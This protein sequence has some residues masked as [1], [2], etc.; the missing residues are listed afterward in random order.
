MN[1]KERIIKVVAAALE[2][3]PDVNLHRFPVQIEF[4][5]GVLTLEGEVERIT[6]KKK[7]LEVAAAVSG[8]TGIVDRLRLVP[9]TQMQDDEI[10]DHVCNT[11]LAENSLGSCAVWAI[12]KKKPEVIREADQGVDG[13]IDVEVNDGVVILNGTVTS[14][15]AKRLAGVLAWWVPG[16]R[17]VVNGIEVAPPEEDDD[18]EVVD[19]VRLVL[20]KDPFVNAAQIRVTCRNYAVTLEGIVKNET[21]RQIAEADCWYVFRVDR[22]MNLLQVEE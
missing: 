20:E 3:E 19:A 6:A 13:S 15:S 18:D 2:R 16:S 1:D 4:D 12:V 17:D 7:A 11:L 22:I 8:V 14:L 21:Q 10:R 5:D 9:S